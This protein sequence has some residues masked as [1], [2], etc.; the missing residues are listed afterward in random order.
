V[1]SAP[2]RGSTFSVRLPRDIVLP[3]A[4]VDVLV[5]D[6]DADVR[7]SLV[8]V[9]EAE[10]YNVRTAINGAEAWESLQRSRPRALLLDIMMPTMSGWELLERLR[11]D[12]TMSRL[13]VCVISAS[14]NKGEAL[15][16]VTVLPKPINVEQLLSFVRQHCQQ[17]SVA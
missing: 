17:E 15:P 1:Q 12:P 13:P 9:L 6:D 11:L 16:N 7:E 2:G 14:V 4:R 10:G 3:P 5:V 8:F